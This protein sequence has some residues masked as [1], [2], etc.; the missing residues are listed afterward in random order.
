MAYGGSVGGSAGW[1]TAWLDSEGY[2]GACL[3]VY[4]NFDSRL[5][6][7]EGWIQKLMSRHPN[8]IRTELGMY[9]HVF[10]NLITVLRTW[11]HISLKN[12]WRVVHASPIWPQLKP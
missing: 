12:K 1:G 7:F 11:M 10:Q 9:A 2:V 5:S 4:M 8:H 6:S 3:L